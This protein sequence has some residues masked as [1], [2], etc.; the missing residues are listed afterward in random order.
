[1]INYYVSPYYD[2]Q[3]RILLLYLKSFPPSFCCDDIWPTYHNLNWELV[4]TP[5]QYHR[6]IPIWISSKFIIDWMFCWYYVARLFDVRSNPVWSLP[7]LDRFRLWI[8]KRVAHVKRVTPVNAL[9]ALYALHPH[10]ALRV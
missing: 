6:I 4:V 9:R 1:M 3:L 10:N 2:V 8:V 5:T 7:T